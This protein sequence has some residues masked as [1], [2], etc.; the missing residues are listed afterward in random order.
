MMH[1]E[2]IINLLDEHPLATLS[3]SERAIVEAH[4]FVCASCLQAYQ[5]AVIATALLQERAAEV[6]EP[7]PFFK[8][9]VMAALRER[10]TDLPFSFGAMWRTARAMVA[11]MVT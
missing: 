11:S 5:A 2:H 1:T 8:T 9:R 3:E 6:V 10:Q 4:S 7:T